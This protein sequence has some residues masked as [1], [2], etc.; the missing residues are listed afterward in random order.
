MIPKFTAVPVVLTCDQDEEINNQGQLIE[1]LKEQMLEQE[2]LIAQSRRD[3][4]SVQNDMGR[5]QQVSHSALFSLLSYC[6]EAPP[7]PSKSVYL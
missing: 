1:K 2:E 4:E 3:Y 5:I 6:C 7:T